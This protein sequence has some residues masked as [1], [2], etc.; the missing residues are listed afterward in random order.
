M[1]FRPKLKVFALAVSLLLG[2]TLGSHARTITWGSAVDD[3]LLYSAGGSLVDDVVF[4]LGSF[5]T[6]VPTPSNMDD[7][8]ANWK[9]FDQAAAPAGSG[10]NSSAG[11]VSSTVTMNSDG[12]STYLS[13]YT[14][15]E[16]EQAYIW[17]FKVNQTLAN[18]G[19]WALVTNDS[20]DGSS[21][22]DWTLPAHSDQTSLPLEWR[23]GNA[24]VVV[25]GGLNDVQGAGEHNSNPTVFDLQLHAIV[26]EPG[27]AVLLSVAA[28]GL[29]LRRRRGKAAENN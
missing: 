12:T 26:P 13:P 11:F 27:S 25:F 18:G 17:A 24:T 6:F 7:W 10:F 20:T 22:D 15:A 8:Q 19:E 4:Q 3:T 9:V 2:T 28:F 5:G 16:G 23:L 14:F 21:V 1:T 29:G